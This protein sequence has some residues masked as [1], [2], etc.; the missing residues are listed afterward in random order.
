VSDPAGRAAR[1]FLAAAYP[2]ERTREQAQ[3]WLGLLAR[4]AGAGDGQ[5][6]WWKIPA[7]AS[8]A[9][10]LN[11]RWAVLAAAAVTVGCT[12]F[13][14]GDHRLLTAA[15]AADQPR[16]PVLIR[17]VS[18]I[19]AISPPAGS[20]QASDTEQANARRV[21]EAEAIA[22]A[23]AVPPSLDPTVQATADAASQDGPPAEPSGLTGQAAAVQSR[24]TAAD[25]AGK[26]VEVA[27]DLAG[28]VVASLVSVP[29]LSDNEVFQVVREYLAGLV[30][31]SPLK[32]TFAAW[33]KRLPG[34]QP[35]PDAAA[36][37]VPVPARLEQAATAELSAAF[38]AAGA[39]DPVT[40]PFAVDPA[41][42][43]AQAEDPL[44]GAVD[45][46]NQARYAQQ[47]R[48]PC[49]GCTV[50]GGDGGSRDEPQEPHE[51]HPFEP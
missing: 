49:T 3:R 11:V 19:H 15:P 50:P 45:L 44:D 37:V 22:L 6:R 28:K 48:G 38:S 21:G 2:D 23:L 40:D 34:A 8:A 20:R 35:P 30:E 32:D 14:L 12:E 24:E 51:E 47:D 5:V 7:L 42:L 18:K 39:A 13:V 25:D 17:L 43:G 27:A 29:S 16:S 26:R 41:L 46:V 31:D 1:E 4:Q 33:F 10:V 9:A 36:E